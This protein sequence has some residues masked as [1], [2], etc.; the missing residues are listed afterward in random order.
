VTYVRRDTPELSWSDKRDRLF[1]E[2]RQAYY[3][4]YY[5]SHNGW[6][7]GAALEASHAWRLGKLVTVPAALGIAVHQR[8]IECAEAVITGSPMPTA[9]ALFERTRREL[10]EWRERRDLE[11]FRRSPKRYPVLHETYYQ[12]GVRRDEVERTRAKLRRCVEHLVACPLW[13]DLRRCLTAGGEV[14]VV[15]SL[16]SFLLDGT[17]VYAAPDLV[18]RDYPKAPPVIVDWK[19][20]AA[21]DGDVGQAAVFGLLIR[22]RYG[23]PIVDAH[24]RC[25]IINLAEGRDDQFTLDASDLADAERRIRTSVARMRALLADPARNVAYAADAYPLNWRPWKCRYCPYL[26][27]CRERITRGEQASDHDAA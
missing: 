17:T 15:D 19:T 13:D 9:D 24:C 4:R 11:A 27:M 2:C 8:A 1:R 16:S 10:N 22:E 25:R 23:W 14:L 12:G 5:A 3:L 26:E 20:G 18:Y 6:E 21:F 7:P